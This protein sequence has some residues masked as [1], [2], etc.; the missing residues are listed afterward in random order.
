MIDDKKTIIFSLLI[1]V[2]LVYSPIICEISNDTPSSSISYE[3][4]KNFVNNH[5]VQLNMF[6]TNSQR[7]NVSNDKNSNGGNIQ[8]NSTAELIIGGGVMKHL[9]VIHISS[10]TFSMVLMIHTVIHWRIIYYDKDDKI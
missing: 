3:P 10:Y 6:A 1:F 4:P 5:N 7:N 9:L 8:S 2:S